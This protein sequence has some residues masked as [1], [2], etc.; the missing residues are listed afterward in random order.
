MCG[1]IKTAIYMN[2][3]KELVR[4]PQKI[5]HVL[6]KGKLLNAPEGNIF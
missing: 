2:V 1:V 3:F 5:I 4:N 6:R